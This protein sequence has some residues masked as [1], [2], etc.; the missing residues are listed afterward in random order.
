[1]KKRKK[2]ILVLGYFGYDNNKLDGQ[3]VKTREVYTLLCERSGAEVRYACTHAFRSR[4]ATL[5]RALRDVAWCDTLVIIPCVGALFRLFP[6]LYYLS[7]VFGYKI[8]HIAIGAWHMRDLPSHPRTA[9]M[10]GHIAYNLYEN[11]LLCA[12]LTKAYG[13]TNL[14][15]IPNFRTTVPRPARRAFAFP[16]RLVFMARMHM[17]KGL[18][19]LEA[20][21]QQIEQAGLAGKVRLTL[22]GPYADAAAQ[23][24]TERTLLQHD[25]VVYDGTLAPDDV[26]PAIAQHD[27]LI[28]PTRYFN[29]GFPGTIL[30]AYRAA[31]PVVVTRWMHAEEFVSDG[32]SG[33]IVD[34]D[35]P[36]PPLF[37]HIAHLVTHPEELPALSEGAYR[38]SLRYT[39]D[40][41]WDV[42]RP[43]I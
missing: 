38:E 26:V 34:F 22:Y 27:L 3:T 32:T 2:H 40:R 12:E 41:A 21:A 5:L 35:N 7:R 25:W 33:Y 9:R 13:H 23:T 30:D 24:F 20:L 1:M 6:P 8:V 43:H 42:L 14:G 31:L 39:P 15:V 29:E 10:L 4:P 16:L 18:D 19:V 11:R 37:A 17:M 36:V 28:F